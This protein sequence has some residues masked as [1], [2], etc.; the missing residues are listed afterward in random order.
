MTKYDGILAETDHRKSMYDEFINR[1]EVSGHIV[2]TKYYE[3]L[4]DLEQENIDDL[5][6]KRA[7]LI[8][9]RA[10]WV[11]A[12]GKVGSEDWN[13]MTDDINNTTLA[14]QQGETAIVGYGSAM[15]DID[16]KVF[17][18]IQERISN[19]TDEAEFLIDLLGEKDLFDDNGQLTDEG[20]ATMGLHA[21]NY[22]VHMEQAKRYG[23]EVEDLNAQIAK[24]PYNEELIARRDDLLAKQRESILAAQDEK[25][26]IRDLVEEGIEIELDALQERI[27]KYEESLDAAKDLYDYN[28]KVKNQTKEIANLEKQLAAYENDNSEEAKAKAQQLRVE[29]AESREALEEMEYEKYIEDQKELLDDL[30]TEYEEMLN[31]RLDNVDALLEDIV[32]GVNGSSS[33]IAQIIEAAAKAAGYDISN[34]MDNIWNNKDKDKD[35]V[36]TYSSGDADSDTTISDVADGV[37]QGVQNAIEASD[38][39]AS[40]NIAEEANIN[41]QNTTYT[42]PTTPTAPTAPTAPT[43]PTTPTVPTTPKETY[44][45]GK[46]SATS[47]NIGSG[48]RGKAVKAIQYALNKLGYGN[49]G[50]KKVDGIFGSGTKKAVKSFQKKMGISADGIVGKN[51][52]KKFKAKGYASGAKS[53]EETMAAWTQETGRE[54]IVRPSDGA[55]LTPLAKD[56]SVLKPAASNNIWDMANNPADFIRNNLDLGIGGVPNNINV[57]SNYTQNLSKVEFSF[58]NVQNYNEMLSA[59]Q[60]D[61]NFEKL[62]LSMTID[63]VAGKSSLAK[64]KAIR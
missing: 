54:F 13:K 16:W 35:V 34:E 26:A 44:P 33:Q 25:E 32:A 52:R 27:D 50:T 47:G 1:Q 21:Q 30:Y 46:A 24:D 5:Q 12:G 7:E 6:A 42:A 53:I 18:L 10:D 28:K 62:L 43:T 59:M 39:E 29:L 23:D 49:S 19:I 55:I 2:S 56:D 61:K 36:S 14:I 60:R 9:K 11:A 41:E 3:K 45:Y 15:R 37:E 22:N 64:G 17:D 48:A 20:D 4:K 40:Q 63:R 38:I 58:P 51:T 57:Q 8:Q 31:T